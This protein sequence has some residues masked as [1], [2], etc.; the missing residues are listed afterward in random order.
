MI[1]IGECMLYLPRVEEIEISNLSNGPFNKMVI[2]FILF[3]A[4]KKVRGSSQ[5]TAKWIFPLSL[6]FS[7]PRYNHFVGLLRG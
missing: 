7:T 6:V 2:S 1:I 4:V 5:F 3:F